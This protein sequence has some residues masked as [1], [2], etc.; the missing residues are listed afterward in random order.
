MGGKGNGLGDSLLLLPAAMVDEKSPLHVLTLGQGRLILAE[1]K[2]FHDNVGSVDP[3][4][5]WR[6]PSCPELREWSHFFRWSKSQI[7]TASDS[8]RRDAYC[9]SENGR[10]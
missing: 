6:L 10:D 7:P 5:R 1:R 8:I 4:K 3:S 9:V 2:C